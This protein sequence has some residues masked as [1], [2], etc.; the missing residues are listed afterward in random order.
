VGAERGKYA[1]DHPRTG[2]VVVISDPTSWQAY[3]WWY[4]TAR[5]PDFARRVDIHR[6]PGY[7]PAELFRDGP[8]FQIALDAT[9]VRGSHGAPVADDRQRGVLLSS[10]GEA[11]P[12]TGVRDIDLAGLVL[13]CFAG[14]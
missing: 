6:K 4:D 7:D 13:R 11:L 10:H 1:L 14:K 3:Y 9:R 8:P 12:A 5:A 2:D